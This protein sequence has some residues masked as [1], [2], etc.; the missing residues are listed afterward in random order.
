L[1]HTV[2]FKVVTASG[3]EVIPEKPI[4]VERSYIN[5]RDQIIG[6]EYQQDLLEKE[7]SQDI[8]NQIVT[9]LY[10]IT[11]TDIANAKTPAPPT[12]KEKVNLGNIINQQY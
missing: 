6:T 4:I 5:N 7:M 3:L 8:I 12:P 2:K 1:I 10:A 11:E 9:R